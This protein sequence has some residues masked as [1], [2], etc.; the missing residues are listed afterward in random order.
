MLR[1]SGCHAA[2]I[3]FLMMRSSSALDLGSMLASIARY[4]SSGSVE[5]VL[6]KRRLSYRD[7]SIPVPGHV[8]R[9]EPFSTASVVGDLLVVCPRDAFQRVLHVLDEVV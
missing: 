9:H 5:R 6:M 8:G 3:S 2:C 1:G 7:P 4:G